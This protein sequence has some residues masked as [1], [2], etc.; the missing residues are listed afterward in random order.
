MCGL[1]MTC[2]CKDVITFQKGDYCEPLG[3]NF[4]SPDQI[5]VV[6]IKCLK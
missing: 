6:Q 2:M 5:E 1:C 4:G 3:D